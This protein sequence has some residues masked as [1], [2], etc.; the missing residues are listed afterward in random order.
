MRYLLGKL[1]IFNGFSLISNSGSLSLGQP[2]KEK[3]TELIEVDVEAAGI[4]ES[5]TFALGC[6]L[7]EE[8]AKFKVN[9]FTVVKIKKGF[10]SS[11]G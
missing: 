10:K 7:K 5:V 3:E 2:K 6:P 11:I 9:I 8:K 1:P 4:L